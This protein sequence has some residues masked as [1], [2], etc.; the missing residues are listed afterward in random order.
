MKV[1]VVGIGLIGGS[2]ARDIKEHYPKA[3]VLGVDQNP[4]HIKQAIELDSENDAFYAL[5]A[6]ILYFQNQLHLSGTSGSC[7]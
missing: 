5:L 1:I 2:F 3:E 7:T 4:D 6:Q